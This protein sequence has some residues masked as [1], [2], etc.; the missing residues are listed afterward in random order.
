MMFPPN[1][2]LEE[3]TEAQSP[4]SAATAGEAGEKEDL[5]L[6]KKINRQLSAGAG[7]WWFLWVFG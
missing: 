6:H 1:C 5:E 3:V 4:A 2:Q 7:G